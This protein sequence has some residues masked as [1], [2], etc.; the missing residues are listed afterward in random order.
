MGREPNMKKPSD[1]YIIGTPAQRRWLDAVIRDAVWR[2]SDM[3]P[4]HR[5]YAVM[6]WLMTRAEM[7][8]TTFTGLVK[9]IKEEKERS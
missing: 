7:H 6:A 9:E 8:Q 2:C 4:D 5:R 3:E 1:K